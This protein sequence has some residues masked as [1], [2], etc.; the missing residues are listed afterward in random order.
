[1]RAPRAANDHLRIVTPMPSNEY[2]GPKPSTPKI[3]HARSKPKE[4]SEDLTRNTQSRQLVLAR[5]RR[6]RHRNAAMRPAEV[7]RRLLLYIALVFTGEY[8]F[9]VQAE[10]NVD[11]G[12]RLPGPTPQPPSNESNHTSKASYGPSASVVDSEPD[13]FA[14]TAN[15]SA[16]SSRLFPNGTAAAASPDY[17][18]NGVANPRFKRDTGLAEGHHNHHHGHR[19]RVYKVEVRHHHHRRNHHHRHRG[20]AHQRDT[21]HVH[22]RWENT[23]MAD[24]IRSSDLEQIVAEELWRMGMDPNEKMEVRFAPIFTFNL[25]AIR[26]HIHNVATEEWTANEIAVYLSQARATFLLSGYSDRAKSFVN[27]IKLGD[28]IGIKGI[29]NFQKEH[30]NSTAE[31]FKEK[32]KSLKDTLNFDIYRS[33][34][35]FKYIYAVDSSKKFDPRFE[36]SRGKKADT[37]V[38]FERHDEHGKRHR[39][40]INI[41]DNSMIEEVPTDNAEFQSRMRNTG[42]QISFSDPDSVASDAVFHL[43]ECDTL[44]HRRDHKKARKF[45]GGVKENLI[46]PF[47]WDHTKNDE[48]AVNRDSATWEIVNTAG[49][50]AAPVAYDAVNAL[51]HEDLEQARKYALLD[52]ISLKGGPLLEKFHKWIIGGRKLSASEAFIKRWGSQAFDKAKMWHGSHATFESWWDDMQGKNG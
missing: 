37:A 13:V 38:I 48:R 47:I 42:K 3:T 15:H 18:L 8:V 2:L 30:I 27:S 21:P 40:N 39:Y 29:I 49:G 32:S 25:T 41:Y 36:E 33:H 52:L 5:P 6:E 43:V 22:A 7:Y 4:I 28:N 11:P 12:S 31:K 35:T 1:M 10:M 16:S 23:V 34:G 51:V 14:L 46:G 26:E 9:K 45:S 20:D 24:M 50:L 19:H 44:N 17:P